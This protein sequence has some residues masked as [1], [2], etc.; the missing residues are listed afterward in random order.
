MH[1]TNRRGFLQTSL[2]AAVVASRAMAGR[3]ADEAATK[4]EVLGA[5][6]VIE[7]GPQKIGVSRMAVGTGTYGAGHSS[8]QLRKLGLDGV[9]DVWTCAYE[10]GGFFWDTSD[11]YGTHGAVKIALKKV[12]R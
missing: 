7:L 4:P 12:P 2:A 11:S 1:L 10:K 9:A 8:N 5:G 6:Q 3:A